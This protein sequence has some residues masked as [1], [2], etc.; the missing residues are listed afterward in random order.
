MRVPQAPRWQK[1]SAM[2]RT[3]PISDESGRIQVIDMAAEERAHGGE[4]LD[5][6]H[7]HRLLAEEQGAEPRHAE[8]RQG[9]EDRAGQAPGKAVQ[10]GGL[11]HERGMNRAGDE[12]G[13]A[14]AEAEAVGDDVVVQIDQAGRGQAA[15]EDGVDERGDEVGRAV[16]HPDGEEEKGHAGLDHPVAR[17]DLRAAAGGAA[18][19][20]PPAEDRQIVVPGDRRAAGRAMRAGMTTERLSGMR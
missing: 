6:A 2:P 19:Q 10:R 3:E 15:D 18:A 17:V 11:A 8:Q 20:H 9:A 13:D 12:A 4:K 7:A 1:I 5:V 14:A 16:A